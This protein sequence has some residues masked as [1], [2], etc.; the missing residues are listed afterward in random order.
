MNVE[1]MR[2]EFESWH[3]SEFPHESLN[4]FANHIYMD[5]RVNDR[6]YGFAEAWKILEKNNARY[7]YIRAPENFFHVVHGEMLDQQ[8]DGLI[9]IKES[10]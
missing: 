8:I 9:K 2:A 5:K 10:K 1:Q 7:E 4:T 6:F 3:K